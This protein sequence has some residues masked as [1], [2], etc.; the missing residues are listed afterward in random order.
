MVGS[1]ALVHTRIVGRSITVR[2]HEVAP[3]LSAQLR[4]SL[5]R[6]IPSYYA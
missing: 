1:E 6:A 5:D 2:M 3:L 4:G